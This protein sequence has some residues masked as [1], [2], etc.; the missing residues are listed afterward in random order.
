MND[1]I[2]QEVLTNI[3][4]TTTATT[5][6][7]R[8]DEGSA[9]RPSWGFSLLTPMSGPSSLRQEAPG[10]NVGSHLLWH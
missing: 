5:G 2:P 10:L 9:R 7:H 3:S 1:L 6:D 4:Q 8:G